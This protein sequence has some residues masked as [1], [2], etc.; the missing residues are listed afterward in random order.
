M[1]LRL[2]S[3]AVV[4]LAAKDALG[5]YLTG[6]ING[7]RVVDADLV[8]V[9]GYYPGIQDV[10]RRVQLENGVVVDDFEVSV[11]GAAPGGGDSALQGEGSF[12]LR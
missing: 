2:A 12:G 11:V 5:R 9:L 6:Q 10:F 7:E 8:S 1:S 3:D 4:H